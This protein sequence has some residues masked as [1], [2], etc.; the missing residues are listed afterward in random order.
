MTVVPE[1]LEMKALVAASGDTPGELAAAM[2]ELLPV[3]VVALGPTA[4]VVASNPAAAMLFARTRAGMLGMHVREL[5]AAGARPALQREVHR[6]LADPD[7]LK[8]A[9]GAF[10][11]RGLRAGTRAF[12]LEV[13]VVRTSVSGQALVVLLLTDLTEQAAEAARDSA[14]GERQRVFAEQPFEALALHVGGIVQ[15]ANQAFADLVGT[16][17]G[18]MIGQPAVR[19]AAPEVALDVQRH[20]AYPNGGVYETLLLRADGARVP[21]LVDRRPVEYLGRNA[22][23]VGVHDLTTEVRRRQQLAE[24]NERFQLLFEQSS[25]AIILGRPDGRI[26]EA[27]DAAC[28]LFGCTR[29]DLRAAG[30]DAIVDPSDGGWSEALQIRRETALF[31]G[32]LRCRR[33]DGTTFPADVVSSIFLDAHGEERSTMTFRDATARRDAE[34]RVRAALAAEQDA[35][36]RLAELNVAKSEF[37]SMLTHDFRTALIGISWLTDSLT[38]NQSARERGT[39]GEQVRA[40]VE[41]LIRLLDEVLE[42]D[43]MQSGHLRL[44]RAPVALDS[45]V[46][47]LLA[48]L[49]ARGRPVDVAIP[50][51]LP[52]IDGDADR[53]SQ[54]FVNLLNNADKFSPPGSK[55]EL[56]ARAEQDHVHV[57]IRNRGEPIPPA[58]LERMFERFVRGEREDRGRT[59]GSGLGLAIAHDIVELHGGRIWL[60]SRARLGTRAH[61]M[62]P[63]RAT[64]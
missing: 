39:T 60:E 10:R 62:L 9:G 35:L 47:P 51:S 59:L 16:P 25:D 1:Q 43:R 40:E 34:D 63:V 61:L 6:A 48:P 13:R 52:A 19:F 58:E 3:P 42:L 20:V 49:R 21:V 38:L 18:E 24:T 26:D 53:L 32:E 17:V 57:S 8:G 22:H 41:R 28:E 54:V 50:E 37:I 44:R 64:A 5:F 33:A 31:V 7:E 12:P 11:T 27:N 55:I 4:L 23:L 46:D 15:A 14:E 29:D 36:R 45:L 2:I 56:R 30:R